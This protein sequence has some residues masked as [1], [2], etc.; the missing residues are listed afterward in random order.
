MFSTL[1]DVRVH[2]KSLF[3]PLS[4]PLS[5]TGSTNPDGLR[6][7]ATFQAVRAFGQNH[8]LIH[9]VAD[10][11]FLL[12]LLRLLAALRVFPVFCTLASEIPWSNGATA[13]SLMAAYVF[14]LGALFTGAPAAL[15]LLFLQQSIPETAL[16]VLSATAEFLGQTDEAEAHIAAV[17]IMLEVADCAAPVFLRAPNW[18]IL[19]TFASQLSASDVLAQQP[20]VGSACAAPVEPLPA[21]LVLQRQPAAHSRRANMFYRLLL[22]FCNPS[23]NQGR[24]ASS[25]TL[26]LI[27]ST[28]C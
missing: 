17:H 15:K 25:Q 26:Q 27:H 7:G 6:H 19:R 22:H 16:S 23:R 1:L 18:T 12:S 14:S 8:E 4:L 20:F 2:H 28:L 24:K 21:E 10:G 11:G 13:P 3:G 9:R 5:T